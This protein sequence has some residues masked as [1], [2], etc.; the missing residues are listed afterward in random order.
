MVESTEKLVALKIEPSSIVIKVELP[1]AE[2]K[3]QRMKKGIGELCG[4]IDIKDIYEELGLDD[5]CLVFD[6][7]TADLFWILLP[8]TFSVTKNMV[9]RCVVMF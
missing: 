3:Y 8:A 9:S 5:Y 4:F 1:P 6:D 2:Y 7:L